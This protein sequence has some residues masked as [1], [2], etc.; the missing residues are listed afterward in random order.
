MFVFSGATGLIDQLCFSKYLGGI[1]GSTAYAVSA[2][3]AAFMTG[4]ALGAHFG[5][6]LSRRV[7]EPLRAYGALELLVAATVA[8]TP[9]GFAALE[10]LYI[11]LVKVA[12]HSVAWLSAARW[13]LAM[14]LVVVPTMAMGATL[15]VLCAGLGASAHAA[16]GEGDGL[17]R[18]R[19]LGRLYA[20]NTLGGAMGALLAAYWILPA[21]G[22]SG[23]LFASAALSATLGIAAIVASG[24]GAEFGSAEAAARQPESASP[25]ELSAGVVS[26]VVSG[27]V[28]AR[29]EHLLLSGLAWASGALVFTA[30]VIFTHLLA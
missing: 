28:P 20:A 26:G 19:R 5:G 13:S 16:G 22:L 9:A 25:G 27:V 29:S 10:P 18:E 15:P 21:L 12:P 6:H 23:T 3:L 7:T 4:L 2:V 11:A 17:S 24:A 30:E 14:L 1:V 8:L